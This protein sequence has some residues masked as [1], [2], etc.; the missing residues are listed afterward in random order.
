MLAAR[1]RGEHVDGE[2]LNAAIGAA[3]R[4]VVERQ[5]A[6]GIDTVNDGEQAR[7]SFVTYVQHRM[8]GFGGQ[9]QRRLMADMTDFPTYME[10][11]QRRGRQTAVSLMRAPACTGPVRYT[12][13][14][15]RAVAAESDAFDRALERV[16]PPADRFMTAT[17]PGIVCTV[18]YDQHYGSIE[19]YVDAV[20]D[21]LRTEYEAIVARGYVLQIDAPDLAMERHCF[22]ADR[23]ATEYIAFADHVVAAINRAT[24]GIPR[25]RIRLH[26]CWGN[27]D[28]PHTR[29][30]AAAELLP[31]LYRA[32]VGALLLSMAN[33]RHA[34]EYRVF[35]THPLPPH[36]S[37]VAGV[38]ETTTNYVEH[39]EVVADR[40]ERVAEAIGGS[41]RLMA[42]T[43]CGFDTTAG[44][45]LVAPEVA[46]AKLAALRA[47]ADIAARRLAG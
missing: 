8:D 36:M 16:V 18:M 19:R 17:S 23:P 1:F 42:G 39:P 32:N 31:S 34:H 11:I 6:A 27:Y 30:I 3:T 43:D 40:I 10:L 41:D 12:D 44:F 22:F 15:R 4:E 45:G 25:E 26:V 28:G 7:E 14:G 46:W 9:T 20:A 13:A 5:V 47:G 2:A 38:V 37:L 21:A 33:P 35:R 24:A 29:D